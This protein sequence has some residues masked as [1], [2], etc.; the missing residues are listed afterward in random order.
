MTGAELKSALHELGIKQHEGVTI[1]GKSERTMRR[2]CADLEAIPKLVAEKVE[3]LL[4][5]KRA[6]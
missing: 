3:R 6:A 5:E 1:F 2:Y 4:G